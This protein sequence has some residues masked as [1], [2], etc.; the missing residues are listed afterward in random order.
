MFSLITPGH[1]K[2]TAQKNKELTFNL[3]AN[4]RVGKGMFR[5]AGF[6]NEAVTVPATE[7]RPPY[8]T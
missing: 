2:E 6:V 4:D 5:S 7:L 3:R 8:N 1:P